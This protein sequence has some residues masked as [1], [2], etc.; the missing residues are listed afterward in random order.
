MASTAELVAWS[1]FLRL[2]TDPDGL[3]KRIDRDP[4]QPSAVEAD[5]A[6]SI[7]LVA[8]QAPARP[9]LSPYFRNA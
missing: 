3:D 6:E 7:E 2:V 1:D 4:D 5:V 8:A 9:Q